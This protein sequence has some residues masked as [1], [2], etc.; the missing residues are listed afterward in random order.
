M[1]NPICNPLKKELAMWILIG[2]LVM[3]C[4]L[5]LGYNYFH[6]TQIP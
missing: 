1:S 6:P 3:F 4:L 5:S 2:F